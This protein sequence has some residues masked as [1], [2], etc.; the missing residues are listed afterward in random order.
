METTWWVDREMVMRWLSETI[1]GKR[2][3]ER[4]R[5]NTRC[6]PKGF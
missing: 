1:T 5:N 2:E 6:P 3:R 4:E